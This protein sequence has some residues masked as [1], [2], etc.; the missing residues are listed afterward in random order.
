MTSLAVTL[1][2]DSRGPCAIYIITDSRITWRRAPGTWWDA[3]Q[4]TFASDFSADIFG[5]CGD[6]YFPPLALHQM[7]DIAN[8]GVLFDASESAEARHRRALA[9]VRSAIG[10][11]S[12]AS[13]NSFSIF[14]GARDGK[15]MNSKFR[16][17]KTHY[18]TGKNDWS[19]EEMD[20][21][22]GQSYLAHIDGSGAT[23]VSRYRNKW[24]STTAKGTSRS[25]IWAFCDALHSGEDKYS[26]GPPQLIGVWRVGAARKFGFL[27]NGDRYIAGAK[28]PSGSHF[29]KVDWFNQRFERYDGDKRKLLIGAKK[30]PKPHS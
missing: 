25:A 7:I 20:L 21:T 29:N 1:S 22:D 23:A 8:A 5:Y 3:G 16:V 30:Q 12:D 4:K 28:I 2:V 18:S 14:H 11:R 27:W 17:W 6:A 13:A 10:Q 19:D 15:L 24:Q 9:V 26:G